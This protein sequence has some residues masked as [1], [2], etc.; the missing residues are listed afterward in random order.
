M[1]SLPHQLPHAI[2]EIHVDL[3]G[4]LHLGD[5]VKESIMFMMLRLPHR[6]LHCVFQSFYKDI[7]LKQIIAIEIGRP[8][9]TLTLN[10]SLILW[11]SDMRL[12]SNRELRVF[13]NTGAPIA[14]IDQEI[15]E[16]RVSPFGYITATNTCRN[17][18]LQKLEGLN[19]NEICYV[20]NSHEDLPIFER[21]K[22]LGVV[23]PI[24]KTVQANGYE[25]KVIFA[26]PGNKSNLY[27]EV[28]K[29]IRVKHWLKNTLVFTALLFETDAT[30]QSLILLTS[31]FFIFCL[32]TSIVYV[33]NDLYDVNTD[34]IHEIKR[35]RPIASG[36]VSILGSLLLLIF[37]AM[38][39]ISFII[40]GV[41]LATSSIF[42]L[43]T[44]LF[45][46]IIYSVHIKRIRFL[47]IFIMPIFY[48]LRVVFGLLCVGIAPSPILLAFFYFSL[49][50]LAVLKRT[51]EIQRANQFDR[52]QVVRG[53]LLEDVNKLNFLA[54]ASIATATSITALFWIKYIP[55]PSM[56]QSYLMVISTILVFV[57]LWIL[58][59]GNGGDDDDT[60][61]MVSSNKTFLV[62]SVLFIGIYMFLVK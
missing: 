51:R 40:W 29:L 19:P 31:G 43:F 14:L 10:E 49:L 17:V 50:P 7:P 47:N 37:L 5:I 34:R 12:K 15:I 36:Q 44:Y 9:V 58:I 18:G 52:R 42:V 20:G 3:D 39:E 35:Y 32:L 4:T 41:G 28:L 13:I 46:N 33:I 57:A 54:S 53:Y 11:L 62:C 23:G 8:V 55:H 48:I 30:T 16:S 27:R 59:F 60:F 6:L 22:Y 24:Y 38:A 21:V 1:K 45:A 56:S 61:G 2:K 26:D 25:D